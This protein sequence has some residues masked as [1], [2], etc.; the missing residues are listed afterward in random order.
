VWVSASEAYAEIQFDDDEPTVNAALLEALQE[1]RQLIEGAF[2]GPLDW[3]GLEANELMTKRT[4][5][6]TPKADIGDRANP[7]TEGLDGL[8]DAARRILDA[9]KPHLADSF[10]TVTS[11]NDD[12]EEGQDDS[13]ELIESAEAKSALA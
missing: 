10:E 2:G 4:K 11:V 8:T 5:V 13:A 1:R 3:R 12:N 7:T 9:V 6:V